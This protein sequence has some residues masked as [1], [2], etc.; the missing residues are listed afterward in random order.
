MT[1]A[2][3]EIGEHTVGIWSAHLAP[4]VDFL[5]CMNRRPDGAYVIDCRIRTAV[6][7]QVFDSKDRKT[8]YQIET[9][10][11]EAEAVEKIRRVHAELL[12]NSVLQQGW[13]LLKG[14]RSMSEFAALLQSMPGMHFKKMEPQ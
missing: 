12:K 10:S 13:E 14:A 6:D 1:T 3:I 5:A 9:R 8:W 7:D 11:N 4:G 2:V